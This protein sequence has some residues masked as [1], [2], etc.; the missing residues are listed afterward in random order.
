MVSSISPADALFHIIRY[1]GLATEIASGGSR[2]AGYQR[3][4]SAASTPRWKVWHHSTVADCGT[5]YRRGAALTVRV[6]VL[7]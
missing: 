3:R 2:N 1:N 6:M 4:H 5:G 7:S